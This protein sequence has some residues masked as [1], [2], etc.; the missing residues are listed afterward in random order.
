MSRPHQVGASK[1]AVIN[2]IRCAE[3]LRAAGLV[4]QVQ[5]RNLGAADE[6]GISEGQPK[7]FARP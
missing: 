2:P 4:K 5:G 3:A 6:A 1:A 7:G